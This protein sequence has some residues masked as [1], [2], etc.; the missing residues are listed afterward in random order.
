[1]PLL[2]RKGESAFEPLR[3]CGP[4]L[5]IFDESS[6]ASQ[7]IALASGDVLVLYTDGVT[8][9]ETASSAQFGMQR[10]EQAIGETR[11]ESA[12]QVVDHITRRVA[13]FV[14]AAPQSDDITCVTVVVNEG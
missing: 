10:L 4:P 7:S 9:A 14:N 5:G 1:P 6:Y 13:E 12:R 3:N 11:G 2:L 8:E